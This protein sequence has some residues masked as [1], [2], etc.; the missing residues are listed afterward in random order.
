MIDKWDGLML[1]EQ[2]T[3]SESTYYVLMAL[4]TGV[5]SKIEILRDIYNSSHGGVSVWPG[6]LNTLLDRFEEDGLVCE[7]PQGERRSAYALTEDGCLT[8]E[9]ELLRMRACLDDAL[10]TRAAA[11]ECAAAV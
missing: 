11:W 5:K 8:Y 6:T 4:Y 10:D 9:L 7:V 3:L 2:E 1:E